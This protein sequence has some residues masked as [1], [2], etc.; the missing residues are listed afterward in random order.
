[1]HSRTGGFQVVLFAGLVAGLAGHFV[2]LA[3]EYE[4]VS[5]KF[6]V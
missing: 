1:M 5:T 4:E 2:L 6:F 3:K